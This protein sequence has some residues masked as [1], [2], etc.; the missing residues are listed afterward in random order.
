MNNKKRAFSLIEVVMAL[1][2]LGIAILPILSMYP[3]AL[4]MTVKATTN[5]EWSR[6]SMS[7]VD[8][9]K[10]R[11]YNGIKT[12][13]GGSSTYEKPYGNTVNSGFVFE[14]GS[15]TNNSFESDF[16]GGANVFSINTKGI[17]LDDYKFSVYLEDKQPLTTVGG[18]ELYTTLDLRNNRIVSSSTSSSIIFGIVKMRKKSESFDWDGTP[19]SASD[20]K[21]RDMKFILTPIEIWGD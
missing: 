4:K 10:S 16:L 2:I 9:V 14:T 21:A 19:G 12:I 18:V 3:S 20:E 13:M 17:K 15:Y 7:V 11:G 1:A 8:Y 5:E 6:V